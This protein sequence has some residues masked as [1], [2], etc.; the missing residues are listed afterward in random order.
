M[1]RKSSIPAQSTLS[2][3]EASELAQIAGGMMKLDRHERIT[4][5]DD[6][7]SWVPEDM[8]KVYLAGVQIN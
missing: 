3:L 5:G 6:G 2:V 4:V 8:I 1:K 7:F